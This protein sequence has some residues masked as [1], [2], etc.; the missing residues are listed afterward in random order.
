MSFEL[1]GNAMNNIINAMNDDSLIVFVGAGISANSGLPVWND[2]INEFKIELSLKE[3]DQIDNLKIAQFYYDTWGKQRYYQKL[4]EVL[5]DYK[6][7]QP[8]DIH[9]YIL[10]MQPRHLITTNYD[11]LLEDTMN[12]G[13]VKYGVIRCDD[14]IPYINTQRYLVK[15]HGDL[16]TKNVVLKEN[17]YLDY[18]N[19][20]RMTSTLIK[21][22]IMNHTVL[23]LGYSLNDITFNSIFRLIN[24]Q[25]GEDSKKAYFYTPCKPKDPVIA[26]YK[27]KGVE[28]I[29]STEEQVSNNRLGIKTI[30]F[31]AEITSTKNKKAKDYDSAWK[32]IEFLN[33][34][35]FIE[36]KDVEIHLNLEKSLILFPPDTISYRSSKGPEFKLP[37]DSKLFK[38]LSKKTRINNF[39]GNEIEQKSMKLMNPIL[40]PAYELYLEKK[41]REAK[42][43]FREISNEA[44]SKSDYINFLIAEFNVIHLER[45]ARNNEEYNLQEKLYDEELFD[46]IEKLMSLTDYSTKMAI[47][48]YRDKIFNLSFLH[49]KYYKI[50]SLYDRIRKERNLYLRGGSSANNYLDEL[51]YEFRTFNEFIDLNC[52]CIKHYTDYHKIVDKYFESL[53]IALSNNLVPKRSSELFSDGTST[54]LDRI[55]V[56]DL[57]EIIPYLNV[58]FFPVYLDDYSL[59]KVNISDEAIDYI[60]ERSIQLCENVNK[61][62][63]MNDIIELQKYIEFLSLIEFKNNEKLVGLFEQYPIMHINKKQIRI[64]LRLIIEDE[65]IEPHLYHRIIKSINKQL[66]T[67]LSKGLD[68]HYSNFRNY[69]NILDK[70]PKLGVSIDFPFLKMELNKV[71]YVPNSLKEIE[72]LEDFLKCFYKYL[73]DDIKKIVD[74]ILGMYSCLSKEK[75][76][77]NFVQALMTKGIG[78]FTNLKNSVLRKIVREV[79]NNRE[80]N[81]NVIIFP[82]R[83]ERCALDLFLLYHNKILS[84]DEILNMDVKD[85]LT[86]K[87]P[88]LDWLIYDVRE[89][90]VIEKVLEYNTFEVCKEFLGTD[91]EAK[92][93]INNWAI[94]Q[95]EQEKVKKL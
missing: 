65:H 59:K 5:Y 81:L 23:F 21:S 71:R 29:Y 46:V 20:F 89:D 11:T 48:Y 34:F 80:E 78:D 1:R 4:H 57:D 6:N 13:V 94:K 10:K 18:P 38:F 53:L 62:S 60:L 12:K 54:K 77:L 64:L 88:F 74:D 63:E 37:Q 50:N 75:V 58:K 22:L 2:L 8:N 44:Y 79:K 84:K 85:D 28:V 61:K 42:I 41:Y 95:F 70:F 73:N 49:K 30:N 33:Q 92:K 86:G 31:L 43:K 47:V 17:D 35:H 52:L 7:V 72:K 39:L 69:A 67:I 16:E 9:K 14:D 56:H 24:N 25:F 68:I 3:N 91:S 93:K 36:S 51:K 15:M 87:N 82:D 40:K 26:Y 32:E 83:L 19:K 45:M 27:N 66:D 76:N 55:G 90:T